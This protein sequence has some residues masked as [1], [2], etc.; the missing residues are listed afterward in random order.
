MIQNSQI[1]INNLMQVINIITK[2][3]N[4]KGKFS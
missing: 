1:M 2:D 3:V 4:L